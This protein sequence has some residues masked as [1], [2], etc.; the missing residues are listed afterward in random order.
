MNLM[1]SLAAGDSFVTAQQVT[2]F[3]NVATANSAQLFAFNP[4]VVVTVAASGLTSAI[5]AEFDNHVATGLSVPYIAGVVISQNQVDGRQHDRTCDDARRRARLCKSDQHHRLEQ[6]RSD[7]QLEH[8]QFVVPGRRY[9]H[10][11]QCPQRRR[12]LPGGPPSRRTIGVLYAKHQPNGVVL[13]SCAKRKL[14]ID[15]VWIHIRPKK[16]IPHRE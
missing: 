9:L 8:R 2:L 1:G 4:G 15:L 5:T 3:D 7:R 13:F 12:L 6:S 14:R 10:C 16:T 11:D